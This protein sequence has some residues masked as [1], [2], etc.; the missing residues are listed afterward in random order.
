MN[1]KLFILASFVGLFLSL[2]VCGQEAE[3]EKIALEGCKLTN[4]YRIDEGV[5]RSEQPSSIDFKVLEEYGIGE[6]LN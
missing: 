5:Y 1:L 6:V 2:G 3:A 4:L